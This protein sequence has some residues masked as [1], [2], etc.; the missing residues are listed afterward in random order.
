[1][2]RN[3]FLPDGGN[4]AQA[5][6]TEPANAGTGNKYAL[7]VA[8][9]VYRDRHGIKPLDGPA[10]DAQL[11]S[12]LLMERYQFDR[13]NITILSEEAGKEELRPTRANIEREFD[14]LRKKVRAG[15]QVVLLLS[16]HGSR[17]PEADPFEHGESKPD[18]WRETFLPADVGKWDE[19]RQTVVNAIVDYELRDWTK[20]ITDKGATV[21]GIVDACHSGTVM[22]SLDGE[23][24]RQ[25]P[26]EELV[27]REVL[28]KARVRT[29]QRFGRSRG[30]GPT[31]ST[32]QI[33]S[34]PERVVAFYA[35]QSEEE[36][37][38]LPL[39]RDT[40]D[41]EPHGLLTFTLC[42]ELFQ[43]PALTYRELMR[44]I[45]TRYVQMGR[46]G[47]TPLIEGKDMDRTV[48]GQQEYVP[49]PFVL[50][51]KA[52]GGWMINGGTLHGLTAGSILE[53]TP[54]GKPADVKASAKPSGYVKITETRTLDADVEPVA[55]LDL[56]KKDA[57][58]DGSGCTPV[59]VD[60]GALQIRVAV[61]V[62]QVANGKATPEERQRL[63]KALQAQ[64]EK[65]RRLQ[66]DVEKLAGASGSL[67]QVV[68]DPTRANWLVTA[69]DDKVY[70]VH[71]Q[72]LTT[73]ISDAERVDWMVRGLDGKMYLIPDDKSA[74]QKTRLPRFGPAPAGD[75]LRPW[76]Q[77]NLGRIAR[78]ENLKRL[79]SSPSADLVRAKDS[80][81]VDV[82]F[83]RVK[84][85]EEQG[86]EEMRWQSDGITFHHKD[87]I[88]VQIRNPSENYFLYATA[89]LIDGN[90][91]IT[92][93]YP[94]KG[95][96]NIKVPPG[97]NLPLELDV[98]ASET[99][100]FEH[101]VVLAVKAEGRPVDFSWLA[102]PSLE[103][104]R[105]TVDKSPLGQL[106][107]S[108]V[109]RQGNTRGAKLRV[110]NDHAL[111]LRTWYTEP[112]NSAPEKK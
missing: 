85:W 111:V 37:P 10:H 95:Q 102:Q 50:K 48:L 21:W 105:D 30:T 36:A 51:E 2:L 103:T 15:D 77:D 106:L 57:L 34:L 93:L 43:N 46:S 44:R 22:R 5:A 66:T 49:A 12:K 14:E 101:L 35:C 78:V 59:F 25:V 87:K 28:Q 110:I 99:S 18:G 64:D 24:S 53:V 58:E 11:L 100:G 68:A 56:P 47:P 104:V 98:D 70:L 79:A 26:P 107:Q 62:A 27:P 73:T 1:M 45:Q 41:A 82:T 17:Q 75:G 96:L 109:F 9:T 16:G 19:K 40:P 108:G 74:G 23:V 32:Y 76:L 91:G 29:E 86:G 97:K 3:A 31:G 94:D 67:F 42:E 4:R 55:Y 81:A 6:P 72:A 13:N 84:N 63:E 65:L 54:P 60:Y 33:G 38:E 92:Q 7:L 112:A 8:C 20:A 69:L 61:L 80:V 89:F 88:R 39:P 90:Y 83:T 71:A 52:K